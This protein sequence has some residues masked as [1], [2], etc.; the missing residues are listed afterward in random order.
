M[1][2]CWNS[3]IFLKLLISLTVF[4]SHESVTLGIYQYLLLRVCFSFLLAYLLT[5]PGSAQIHQS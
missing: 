1:F 3:A 5:C 4:L 2:K